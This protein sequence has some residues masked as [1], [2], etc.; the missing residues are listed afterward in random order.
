MG[1]KYLEMR[2]RILF[3]IILFSALTSNAQLLWKISGNGLKSPSFLFG[4]HHIAPLSICD[5]ID[6][7]KTAFAGCEQLYGEINMDSVNVPYAQMKIAKYMLLPSD[8]LLNTL[9]SASEYQLVDSV[10]KKY[11]GFGAE[12]FNRFK[13]N[14]VSAQLSLVQSIKSFNGYNP[15]V[16][17]DATLQK[18]AKEQGKSVHGFETMEF[19]AECLFDGPL[20]EQ[21]RDLLKMVK[22]GDRGIEYVRKMTNCY[23][24]QDIDGMLTLMSDRELGMTDAE[25][26]KLIDNRNRN[27]EKQLKGIL[28]EKPTF[29]VVGAG[30]LIGENG[31]IKLL[32]KLG[33]TLS[34]VD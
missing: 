1:L 2:R 19:Q 4:T 15:Q 10:L 11:L 8:S 16:Q 20:K 23:M 31:L 32:R 12:Q 13:P 28:P 26:K 6:G 21:A 25:K 22:L 7:F 18:K 14:V 3:V 30:H 17:L 29:I 33:Y 24:K 5:S 27:W 9:Y 34:P